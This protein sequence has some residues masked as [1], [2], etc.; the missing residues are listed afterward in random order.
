MDFKELTHKLKLQQMELHKMFDEINENIQLILV[1][2]EQKMYKYSQMWLDGQIEHPDWMRFRSVWDDKYVSED[3]TEKM[4][5][6]E[7]DKKVKSIEAELKMVEALTQNDESAIHTFK[8]TL[9][10]ERATKR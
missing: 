4:I 5:L 2:I 10:F 8:T 9:D 7:M 1:C 3:Y 6:E